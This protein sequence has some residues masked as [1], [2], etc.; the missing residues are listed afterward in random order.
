MTYVLDTEPPTVVISSPED[1]STINR[2]AVEIGGRTQAL[3]ELV[4]RN[5]ANGKSGAAT[6][7]DDGSFTLSV[8]IED[9]PNGI[10]IT[11]TDPAGNDGIGRA[12]RPARLGQAH[13]RPDRVRLPDRPGLAPA[14]LTVRIVVTDPDGRPL[15]GASVL[16]TITIPGIPP[17][18]PSAVTTDGAGSASFRTTIPT[19]ATAGVGQITARVTTTEFGRAD[20]T[21]GG[22][23]LAL[24]GSRRASGCRRGSG[25]AR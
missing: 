16:F 9:G 2:A 21:D 14:P 1:G 13:R 7:A 10:T 3:S 4:A 8:P 23:D 12:D 15:E 25:L 6:A 19:A 20:G 11:A 17:I 22:D 24:T 18:V 5:E